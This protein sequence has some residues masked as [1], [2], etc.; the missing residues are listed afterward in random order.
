MMIEEWGAICKAPPTQNEYLGAYWGYSRRTSNGKLAYRC[1]MDALVKFFFLISHLIQ[2]S[3]F[4]H[5]SHPSFLKNSSFFFQILAS[6]RLPMARVVCMCN[7]KILCNPIQLL[8]IKTLIFLLQEE[9]T[10][11]THI[12]SRF[13]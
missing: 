11:A 8:L 3:S 2:R 12:I 1:S 7:C 13:K 10:Y 9:E 6:C 4:Q 5:V